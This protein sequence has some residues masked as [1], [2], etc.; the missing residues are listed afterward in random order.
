MIEP[1][2]Q[3]R[4]QLT[5][6]E[7]EGTQCITSYY[8]D[9]REYK[10]IFIPSTYSL[11]QT[12]LNNNIRE[13]FNLMN[14]LGMCTRLV[15]VIQRLKIHLDPVAWDKV[16]KLADDYKDEELTEERIR[17]LHEKLRPYFL[18]RIKSEVLKLPPKV[19]LFA[20]LSRRPS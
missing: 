19:G 18:R 1:S 11:S 16:D 17:E 2:S 4:Q 3:Q 10:L 15:Q 9:R 14:F 20:T 7:A 12:P 6:Q 5:F 8:H 13:L